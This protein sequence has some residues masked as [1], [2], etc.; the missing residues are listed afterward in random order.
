MTKLSY[1][2]AGYRT[3]SYA[4]ALIVANKTGAPITKIFTPI[5]SEFKVDAEKRESRRKAIHDKKGA[6]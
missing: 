4:E 6:R 5:D 3:H 1:S 2:V